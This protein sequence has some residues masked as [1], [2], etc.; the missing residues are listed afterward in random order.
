MSKTILITGA[1]GGL[2]SA[3]ARRL[4][5]QGDRLA[6]AGRDRARL[7]DLRL[8]GALTIVAD[9]S[10]P[11]GAAQALAQASAHF[12][13]P[14]EAL[15]HCAGSTLLAPL[16]RTSAEQYRACLAA[17][18]DSA[19]YTLQAFVQAL[20]AAK[21]PGAAALVSSVVAR[22]GVANHEAIAAAKGA[23][24]GLVR[25]AAASYSAQGIRVNAIAP[26]LMRTPATERLFA[27]GERAVEQIAAQYP[28][29]RHGRAEDGAAAMAW[30]LSDEAGWITGQVLPVDGGFTAV[31]PLVKPSA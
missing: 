9:C 7:D 31:R 19:F 6:L 24:E 27:G 8:D 1:A 21:R 11:D 22:S 5:A 17:N 13:A 2:G 29:G 30:L 10:T 26:G 25:A 4:H 18:L 3:L 16:H 14:P 12:G 20:L 23:I 28:L 15:A